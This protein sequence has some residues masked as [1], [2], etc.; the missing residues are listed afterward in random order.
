MSDH[1]LKQTLGYRALVCID[2]VKNVYRGST[3][4]IDSFITLFYGL[5]YGHLRLHS[6]SKNRVWIC[7]RG[8]V[9]MYV[10]RYVI[11]IAFQ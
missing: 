2:S 4:C 7:R 8:G 5:F 9:V 6:N 10:G 1:M 11:I 3:V